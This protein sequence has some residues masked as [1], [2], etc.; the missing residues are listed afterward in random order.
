METAAECGMTLIDTADVYGSDG[1]G[2]GAAESALGQVFGES[3][4]TP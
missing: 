3:P 4:V 1:S 2:F